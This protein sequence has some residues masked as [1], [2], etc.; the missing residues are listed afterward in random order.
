MYLPEGGVLL[1]RVLGTFAAS[2]VLIWG[3]LL[4]GGGMLLQNTW[5]ALVLCA[6]VVTVLAQLFEG[7][8]DRVEELEKRVAAL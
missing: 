2:L 1:K 3:F 7:Q 8:A 5:G 6:L 4:F